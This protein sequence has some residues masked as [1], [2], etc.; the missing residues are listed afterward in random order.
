MGKKKFVSEK[1][2]MIDVSFKSL[3]RA[4]HRNSVVAI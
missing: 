2:C 4:A 3:T 1:N